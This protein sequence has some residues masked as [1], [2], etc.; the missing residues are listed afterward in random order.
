MTL[1]AVIRSRGTWAGALVFSGTFLARTLYDSRVPTTDFALRSAV[2][3]WSGVTTLFAVGFWAAWQSRSWLAGPLTA[4]VTS[5]IA[6]VIS[7]AESSVLLA[8]W[9]DPATREAIVG[10]GGLGEVYLL[11]FM[12][13]IPAVVVGTIGGAAGTLGRLIYSSAKTN[14]A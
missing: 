5:Q 7:V 4:A 11:P 10:S 1:G 9:H 8:I 13:I 14:S 2:S 6:A 12:M 3:T